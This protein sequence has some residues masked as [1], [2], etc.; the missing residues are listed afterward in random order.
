MRAC[1]CM[2]VC[3][4]V[5]CGSAHSGSLVQICHRAVVLPEAVGTVNSMCLCAC[6]RGWDS[7][8]TLA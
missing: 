6:P 1:A 2:C 8:T 4:F 5:G 7:D 3:V